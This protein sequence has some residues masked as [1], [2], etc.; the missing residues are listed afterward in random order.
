MAKLSKTDL[1]KVDS[2]T[3]QLKYWWP[4][5]EMVHKGES[6]KLGAQ[7]EKGSIV[8]SDKTKAATNRM[9]VS[10]R[11]CITAQQVKTYLTKLGYELPTAGGVSVKI[12][13]LW[14][15]NVKPQKDTGTEAKIGGR[16]TEVF[17]EVLAQFCLAYAIHYGKAASVDA[18]L[19]REGNENNIQES[20]YSAC[21]RY[22]ITPSTFNLNNTTFRKKLA[23]FASL[24]MEK[25][26]SASAWIDAQGKAML[27]L[28]EKYKI[29]KDV[30]IY[31]DKIFDGG[32]FT[33]NP[34]LA[35][36]KAGT[37]VGG[38]K[39]NPADMWVMSA[40][41]V[42]KL[43]HLNRVI[44]SRSKLSVNVANNFL[45]EQFKS[46]D[47]IPVS[48]KK[49][50]D[51]AHI[52]VVNSDEFIERVVLGKTGNPTIE[53]TTDN[54]DMKINF[55]LETVQIPSTRGLKGAAAARRNGAVNG[56]VVSGS[57][58]HIR[59]KYH[60]NNKKI[61]LE[62]T[63]TGQ[64]SL[65]KAKM[66]SLGNKNFQS[67]INNTVKEGVRKLNKIQEN[68]SDINIKTSPWFNGAQ[69]MDDAQYARLQGYVSEIWQEITGDNAPDF[70]KTKDL[71]T[72]PNLM[73]KA[74]AAE[75]GLAVGGISSD[76][77]KARLIT[78]LYE[79]CASVAFG[80]GLT[81]EEQ[82]ILAASGE[83]APARKTQF[84]GSVHV[85]VY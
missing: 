18:C 62:Y 17:S 53:I 78:F 47:I 1:T 57:Q 52:V 40:K 37:G 20:V 23:L 49:P 6:F 21:K 68:Y 71:K 13:D 50:S 3:G 27:K 58:K 80:S 33:A 67:V 64:P 32:S 75:L 55:T 4:F 85:K 69:K 81:K 8:I 54:R 11:K 45:M 59:I 79:A 63:Q 39:W 44:K 46:G 51:P 66:G 61:E 12:T 30:K 5:I 7:G 14:K 31:N 25:T 84:Q 26:A 43:V 16:E 70:S 41:G 24:P 65:A 22:I 10:M 36:E 42:Q 83:V 9:L 28:K 48:L 73:D 15:E 76:R 74:R 60:V 19:V 38:D 2:K 35:F 34:Y 56:K 77:I 82:E 29:G 72:T